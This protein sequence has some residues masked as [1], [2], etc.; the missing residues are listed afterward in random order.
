[1]EGIINVYKQKG[2]SSH[3]VV[4]KIRKIFNTKQV[5]HTGT[6]D[7]NAEGVLVVCLN[8]AT[9]LVQFLEADSKKYR[10]ELILGIATDTYDITGKVTCKMNNFDISYEKIKEVINSFIGPQK[11]IPPIYSA[12]KVNGKKLYDYALNNQT[13]EITARDINIYDIEILDEGFT[14]YDDYYSLKFDVTVSKGTYIRSL[15]NDIGEKLNI[16][17]TMG[18]LLRLRSGAFLIE[19]AKTLEQ[20]ENGDYHL[21]GLVESLTEMEKIDLTD[22]SELLYKVNNGMKLSLK[23][24]PEKFNRVAFI[25]NR[26]LLAIYEYYEEEKY[27]YYRAVRVWK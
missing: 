10:V 18:D 14:K 17:C 16:P 24:F 22:N 11:Q 15:C 19:E 21:K 23:S 8:S 26:K 5:G 20:I 6:L 9:K 27:K 4:N 12:I 2:M 13:V 25:S 3:D 1:M 7:P